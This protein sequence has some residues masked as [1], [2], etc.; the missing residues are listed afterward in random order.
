MAGNSDEYRR[1]AQDCMRAASKIQTEEER[2]I[3]LNIAGTWQRL[4]DQ[5][6]GASRAPQVQPAGAQPVGQQTVTK[7]N[8][9]RT[10]GART[11]QRAWGAVL[12]RVD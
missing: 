12:S 1:Y 10:C 4:A 9:S 8:L 5:E 7:G 3:L 6:E 11:S 2:K